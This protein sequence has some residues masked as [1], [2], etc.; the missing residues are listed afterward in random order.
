MSA[1]ENIADIVDLLAESATGC[2]LMRMTAFSS[3]TIPTAPEGWFDYR[4]YALSDGKL[5]VLRADRDINA[6]YSAWWALT[7]DATL[8]RGMPDFWKGKA[9]ISIIDENGESAP[10]RV[11]L[12]RHPRIDRFADGRWLVASSRAHSGQPN[13]FVLD[14]DGQPIRAVILGD[15]IEHVR[16]ASDGTI[17]VGYFDEGIGGNSVGSGGIVHFDASGH[18]LW[19]Y[20]EL[21]PAGG[22][23]IVDC[24]ALSLCGDELWSCFYNDF[25][26][27][28]VKD[29][30]RTRWTNGITGAQA[31]AVD[32]GFLL[33]AGGY[34][35]DVSRLAL[36]ELAQGEARLVGSIMCPEIENASLLSGRSSEVHVVNNG[37]WTRI[38]VNEVRSQLR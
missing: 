29:R 35:A 11:P 30:T 5:A 8:Q 27:L 28:R 36:L 3:V 33:L 34:G 6:E 22:T 19:S 26:I 12:V 38:T 25:T 37:T 23:Y 17:W 15:G 14:E 18:T 1:Q 20:N 7:R 21:E 10:I 9:C 13:G 4:Y 16:C 24:Y 31:L 32:G 2:I